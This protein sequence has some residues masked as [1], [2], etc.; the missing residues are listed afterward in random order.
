MR[1]FCVLVVVFCVLLSAVSTVAETRWAEIPAS[2]DE[3]TGEKVRASVSV[4]DEI[5]NERLSST[6]LL[7]HDND[8]KLIAVI[9]LNNLDLS[10]LGNNDVSVSYRADGEELQKATKWKRDGR[11][12]LYREITAEEGR[13]LFAGKFLIVSIDATGKRYRYPFDDEDGDDLRKAV[14]GLIAGGAK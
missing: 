8:G 13:A 10:P 14:D 4:M 5:E 12:V 7:T 1:A 6:F 3:L 9:G 2:I 11:H